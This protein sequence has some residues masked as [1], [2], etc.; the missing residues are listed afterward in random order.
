MD[1]KKNLGPRVN[2]YI[3]VPE[4]QLVNDKGENLG[5]VPTEKALVLAKESE[6]DLVEVGPNVK[7]PV[8]KIMDF[9][10]YIYNQS[11]KSRGNKKGKAKEQKEFRFSPVIEEADINHR[12]RRSKEYLEKGH[13]VKIVMQKKGRQSMEQAKL[14]FTEILTNFTD[15]SSIEAEP[16]YEGNRISMTFKPNG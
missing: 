2:E 12:V 4:V 7:P 3:R 1:F 16:K 6:L 9:S 10:K 13:P 14:V 5:V 8:C 11:K 15:Y